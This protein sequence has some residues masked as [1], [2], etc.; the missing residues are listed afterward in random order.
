[1][2]YK[3]TGED[4]Q[5]LSIELSEGET[6]FSESGGMSWMSGNMKMETE[7]RGMGQMFS[8]MLTGESLF[9]NK[10]SSTKGTGTISFSACA[11][12]KILA[13]ELKEGERLICQK[14]AFLCAQEGVQVKISFRM[15]FGRGLFGGE[16]FIM[17][18]ITGPGL[19]FLE[20]D[21]ETVEYTLSADQELCVDNGYIAYYEPT[22]SYDVK[23]IKGA[24][25]ILFGGEGLFL[26]TVKGPG[27]V[28]LQTMPTA[29]LAARI[30][31]YIPQ[32]RG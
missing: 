16:G 18:E 29:K 2:Q 27:K 32:S 6:I 31:R 15:K 10:Y 1:M 7:S 22:V 11:P 25:N 4:M 26:A 17:Q 14:S 13:I 28:V 24:R 12:G 8:R 3:I 19:V 30:A 20:I 5:A 21:G 23:M 9:I